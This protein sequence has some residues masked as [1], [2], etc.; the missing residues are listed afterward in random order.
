MGHKIGGSG[1]TWNEL[2]VGC[3]ESGSDGEN[4]VAGNTAVFAHASVGLPVD[5]AGAYVKEIRDRI[6]SPAQEYKAFQLLREKHRPVL[7]WLLSPEGPVYGA[8]HMHLTEGDEAGWALLVGENT[9]PAP[10]ANINSSV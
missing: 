7:E 3:D 10:S 4:L 6:R 5:T 8:A 2:E 9:L 1:V